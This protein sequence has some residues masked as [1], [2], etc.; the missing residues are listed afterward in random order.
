MEKE[1]EEAEQKEVVEEEERVERCNKEEA[2]I[3]R[4]QAEF[5][6]L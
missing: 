5:A 1:I 4:R 3:K 2:S 6:A